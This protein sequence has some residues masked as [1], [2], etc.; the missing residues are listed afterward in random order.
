MFSAEPAES[1]PE[2]ETTL[3]PLHVL[4]HAVERRALERALVAASQNRSL[5]ARLPGN[6]RTQLYAKLTE[7]GLQRV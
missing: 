2:V 3:Q 1:A 7:H 6:S 5:A 4:L